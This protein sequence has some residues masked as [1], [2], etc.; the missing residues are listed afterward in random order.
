MCNHDNCNCG[1]EHHHQPIDFS[2]GCNHRDANGI[3]TLVHI[4]P[5]P[6]RVK[7]GLCGIE[8]NLLSSNIEE[9]EAMMESLMKK[10]NLN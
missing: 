8:F 6:N 2:A 7:C 4:G 9:M 1:H 3:S 10:L 5:A